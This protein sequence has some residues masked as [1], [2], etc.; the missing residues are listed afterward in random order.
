MNNM[1]DYNVL[2]C[3]IKIAELKNVTNAAKEL[4]IT[5]PALSRYISRLEEEIGLELFKRTKAGMEL[6]SEGKIVYKQSKELIKAYEKFVLETSALRGIVTG[7]ITI[8]FPAM[9]KELITHFNSMVHEIYPHIQMRSV[10][11]THDNLLDEI[12][13]GKLDFAYMYGHELTHANKN[14]GNLFVRRWEKKLMLSKKHPLAARKK[15]HMSE[16]GDELFIQTSQ[17]QSP[18]KTKEFFE[19]CRANGF[20][21]NILFYVNSF[22][23]ALVDVITYNAI[24]I[25]PHFNNS[26][27]L[28]KEVVFVE[29]EGMDIDYPL[30]LVWAKENMEASASCYVEVVRQEVDAA[31][32]RSICHT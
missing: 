21:P 26:D 19:A 28:L 27:E 14:I 22:N 15:I 11:Q 20:T 1:P 6:T 18:A 2:N 16:L 29:I 10:M 24:S 4:F 5:Q 7:S 12:V 31:K 25:M 13:S 8:G 32:N 17:L 9:C 3:F 23:E 30:H